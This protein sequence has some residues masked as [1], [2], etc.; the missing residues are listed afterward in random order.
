[1]EFFLLIVIKTICLIVGISYFMKVI[2]KIISNGGHVSDYVFIIFFIFYILPL[3]L[4][5]VI[6][7]PKLNWAPLYERSF[8]DVLTNIFYCIFI[9]FIIFQFNRIKKNVIIGSQKVKLKFDLLKEVVVVLFSLSP[10]FLV[11]I[12]ENS[13]LYLIY[14]DHA[15]IMIEK[16]PL[17]GYIYLLS[18]V[19]VLI[20]FINAISLN[21]S[22]KYVLFCFPIIFIDIWLNG[23]RNIVA[24]VVVFF[25]LLLFKNKSINKVPKLFI[26]FFLIISLYFLNSF[27]QNNIRTDK[28][29]E[30]YSSFR[31]DFGRDAAMKAGIYKMIYNNSEKPILEYPGQSFV[32]YATIFIPRDKWENKPLP[33]A[34]YFTSA[35]LDTEPKMWGWGLTTS[36]FEETISNFSYLGFLIGPFLFFRFIKASSK[37]NSKIF[38]LFTILICSI[39]LSVEITAYYILF[40]LWFA[41]YFYFLKY[42]NVRFIIK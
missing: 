5:I 21:Y 29:E 42:K 4:D 2:K 30:A 8:N 31:V 32:F 37:I 20:I 17:P 22:L 24:L 16:S 11:F 19:S 13:F 1:M 9:I 38:D 34:Q 26:S 14:K 27:Y 33:Y 36:F 7:V 6:G 3:L 10:L 39:L 15:D 28:P 23:K 41:F 25:I 18:S 35:V 12:Y 40:V